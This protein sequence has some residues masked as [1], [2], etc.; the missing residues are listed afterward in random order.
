[1]MALA[2][3]TLARSLYPSGIIQTFC[4]D[5]SDFTSKK[6]DSSRDDVRNNTGK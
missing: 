5:E 3:N 1:M 6:S 4:P 2:K